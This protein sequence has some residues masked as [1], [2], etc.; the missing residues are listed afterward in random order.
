MSC[1]STLSLRGQVLNE[2]KSAAG[3]ASERLHFI[4]LL[5]ARIDGRAVTDDVAEIAAQLRQIATS[6]NAALTSLMNDEKR[7]LSM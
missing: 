4:W 6:T 3:L 2:W 5:F 1:S 7:G